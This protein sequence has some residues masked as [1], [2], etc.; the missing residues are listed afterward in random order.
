MTPGYVK[1]FRAGSYEGGFNKIFGGI[2]MRV[3]RVLG[4]YA[5][6]LSEGRCS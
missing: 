4:N 6:Y 2:P 5:A 1:L 3:L